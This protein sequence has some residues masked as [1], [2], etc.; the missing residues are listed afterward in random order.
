MLQIKR[1]IKIISFN[2][3]FISDAFVPIWD[4]KNKLPLNKQQLEDW[5]ILDT[6]DGIYAK[7]DKPQKFN[8]VLK[9]LYKNNFK[10]INSNKK[11]NCFQTSI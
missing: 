7:Y 8:D 4:Y 10:I 5:S 11:L 6:L 9:F 2:S 3:D 1:F